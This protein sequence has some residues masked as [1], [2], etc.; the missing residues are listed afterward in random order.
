MDE[1]RA[2]GKPERPAWQR[3]ETERQIDADAY[4]IWTPRP[5]IRS[6]YW[7]PEGEPPREAVAG[8]Y[9]VFIDQRAF[10]AMHEHVWKAAADDSPF[11]YL[12]GDL[13]EDPSAGRRFIIVNQVVPS[14]FPFRENDPEQIGEE[15][16]V[17]LQ[18]EVE[19]K[20]GSLVGWYHAHE[21]GEARLSE[22]D[23]A[24]H[25]RLFADAWHIAVLV[26]TDTRHPRGATFRRTPD[27]L[28]GDLPLPFYEMVTNESLLAKGIRRSRMDWENVS[29]LDGVRS[30]PPPRPQSPPLPEV[31]EVPDVPEVPED[32]ERP[33][34]VEQPEDEPAVEAAGPE[35]G[36]GPADL[37]AP[38]P[39]AV[40]PEPVDDEG[41][42]G[43]ASVPMPPSKVDDDLDFDAIVAEVERAG[44]GPETDEGLD[45]TPDP[46]PETEHPPESDRQ[47]DADSAFD[48]VFQALEEVE[49]ELGAQ[50]DERQ[51]RISADLTG[52]AAEQP[53]APEP[54]ESVLPEVEDGYGSDDRTDSLS[55]VEPPEPPSAELP[56]PSPPEL[57]ELS[58]P[59]TDPVPA[60]PSAS[61]AG[62]GGSRRRALVA[63]GLVVA[64]ASAWGLYQLIGSGRGAELTGSSGARQPATEL[65]A[66]SPESGSPGSSAAQEVEAEIDAA[67]AADSTIGR[68]GE[69]GS[70]NER[71]ADGEVAQPIDAESLE[72]LSDAVLES[73]SSFYGR[74]GAFDSEQIGC[75][76]LQSSF[77]EVMDSWIDY[78]TR[79]KAGWQGRLPADLEQRDERLYRGVQD[80]ERLFEGTSCP[81]P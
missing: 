2:D 33:A 12:V 57:P 43:V 80:V 16:S 29:T 14:R 5:L 54:V 48:E 58:P 35:E 65:V 31:L 41:L 73:I 8:S 74:I 18:L 21:S 7:R 25:D 6:V 52:G 70:G 34:S 47:R 10:V 66:P 39:L 23:V 4:H 44:L 76:E 36:T 28:D 78:N 19:R 15:A 42:D 72:R 37:P 32:S 61:T 11:G 45:V 68:E 75:A 60:Q 46:E 51:P 27:G 63:A 55:A 79:G 56:E 9:E 77:V 1:E 71:A 59:E 40:Q 67:A 53:A 13:C 24:T 81:R 49:E 26:V 62:A 17:A 22:Y 30:E 50:V 69:S 20:R 3:S 38:E 64:L